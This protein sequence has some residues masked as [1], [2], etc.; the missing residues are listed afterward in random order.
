MIK[1]QILSKKNNKPI[2]VLKKKDEKE[3]KELY[4]YTHIRIKTPLWVSLFSIFT[5]FW[6]LFN[7][8][9]VKF[10]QSFMSKPITL[11]DKPYC[12]LMVGMIAKENTDSIIDYINDFTEKEKKIVDLYKIN[13]PEPIYIYFGTEDIGI[14]EGYELFRFFYE[15]DSPQKLICVA[16]H[17]ENLAFDIFQLCDKRY[18]LHNT[19]INKYAPTSDQITDK[20]NVLTVN[21]TQHFFRQYD[22]INVI[23]SLST[24]TKIN[25]SMDEYIKKT[26]YS[27]WEIKNPYLAIKYGLA[28]EVVYWSD[29]DKLKNLLETHKKTMDNNF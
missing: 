15:R 16:G 25:I 8:P 26:M 7:F 12:I 9:Y 6:F 11:F 3:D 13:E 14:F 10:I 2:E 17:L 5:L 29:E 18:L 27:P 28:D 19:V 20:D 4:V 22:K 21:D 24:I 23:T 1:K